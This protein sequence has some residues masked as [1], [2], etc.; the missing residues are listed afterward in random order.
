MEQFILFEVSEKNLVNPNLSVGERNS[1]MILCWNN[2]SII[3]V[4]QIWPC[5]INALGAPNVSTSFTPGP[6][7]EVKSSLINQVKD[8]YQNRR[9]TESNVDLCRRAW[10]VYLALTKSFCSNHVEQHSPDC[11]NFV[12]LPD[13]ND[14][15]LTLRSYVVQMFGS[16]ILTSLGMSI[17]LWQWLTSSVIRKFTFIDNF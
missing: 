12:I 17:I 9:Y 10:C 15:V 8:I 7:L 5:N 13:C 4:H 1:F 3:E 6:S 2:P 14:V 16:C 11:L